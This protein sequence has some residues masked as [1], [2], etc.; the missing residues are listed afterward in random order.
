[1]CTLYNIIPTSVISF[2]V[3]TMILNPLTTLTKF[4]YLIPTNRF[5]FLPPQLTIIFASVHALL[6]VSFPII[7]V[8]I[9]CPIT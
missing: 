5:P 1:M 8:T 3:H 4:C 9:I 2:N 6:L 7:P